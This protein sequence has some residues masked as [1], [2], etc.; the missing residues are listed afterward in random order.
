MYIYICVR[1]PLGPTFF[2]IFTLSG[3]RGH[4]DNM[5]YCRKYRHA[6][7]GKRSKNSAFCVF[8]EKATS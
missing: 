7:L 1:Q 3:R 5:D 6:Y 4:G 2:T 8:S